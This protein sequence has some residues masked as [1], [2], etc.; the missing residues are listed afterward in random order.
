MGLWAPDLEWWGFNC[1]GKETCAKYVSFTECTICHARWQRPPFPTLAP[2]PPFHAPDGSIHWIAAPPWGY[3]C[4][5]GGC[6]S[7]HEGASCT[8]IAVD[9]FATDDA[10]VFRAHAA[11]KMRGEVVLAELD[12]V[13]QEL[14]DRDAELSVAREEVDRWRTRALALAKQGLS[15]A[16]L[17]PFEL[18]VRRKP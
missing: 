4:S 1:H 14:R 9:G 2:L 6:V 11:E 5:V 12:Q 8:H 13:R 16:S 18:L 17:G 15:L 3:A 7:R 10:A